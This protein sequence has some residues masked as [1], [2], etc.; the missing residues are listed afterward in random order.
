[1]KKFL[2][3]CGVAALALIADQASAQVVLDDTVGMSDLVTA[4]AALWGQI[5]AAMI[6]AGFSFIVVRVFWAKASK[7]AG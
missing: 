1:M 7:I 5:L 2:V 4:F 6:A 3:F